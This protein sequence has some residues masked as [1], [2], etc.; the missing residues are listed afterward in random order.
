MT[1]S[2]SEVSFFVETK[3]RITSCDG[4]YGLE[5]FFL[6]KYLIKEEKKDEK[7][8]LIKN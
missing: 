8:V 6:I 7:K 3:K 1:V 2:Y 4:K 5:V